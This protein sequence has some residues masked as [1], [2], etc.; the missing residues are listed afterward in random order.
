[1]ALSPQILVTS[2][3]G[4]AATAALP[5]PCFVGFGREIRYSQLLKTPRERLGN[6]V[7]CWCFW[8]KWCRIICFTQGAVSAKLSLISVLF[9]SYLVGNY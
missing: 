3:P 7:L 5:H 1:M 9:L 2:Q 4:P 8:L 6:F